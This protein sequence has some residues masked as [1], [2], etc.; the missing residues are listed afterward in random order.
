V[1]TKY[2]HIGTVIGIGPTTEGQRYRTELRKV[3]KWWETRQLRR[4]FDAVGN[5]RV[6]D[7]SHRKYTLWRLDADS[8]ARI[9][10]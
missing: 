3:G 5:E 2:T 9:K 10:E 4:R 8:I 1:I 7:C 6:T